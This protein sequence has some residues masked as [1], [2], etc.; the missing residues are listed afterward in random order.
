MCLPP[1]SNCLRARPYFD[2]VHQVEALLFFLI[3][4]CFFFRYRSPHAVIA[5]AL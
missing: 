1:P 3:Y 4:F 5:C 2:R